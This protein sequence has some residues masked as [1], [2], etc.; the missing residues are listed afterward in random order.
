[1]QGLLADAGVLRAF[2]IGVKMAQ[3]ETKDP[4]FDLRFAAAHD[5][6][7]VLNFMK[8]L[9]AYQKMADQITGIVG[10]WNRRSLSILLK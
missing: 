5:A 4:R 9:G 3:I 1:M 10:V 6:G 8:K 2:A 7:L